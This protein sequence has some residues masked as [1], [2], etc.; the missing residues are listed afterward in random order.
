[1]IGCWAGSPRR[2]AQAVMRYELYGHAPGGKWFKL[3][4]LEELIEFEEFQDAMPGF[5]YRLLKRLKSGQT[6]QMWYR[7][8]PGPGK[9]KV[10]VSFEQML[11]DL[12]PVMEFSKKLEGMLP[13]IRD[14]V[15]WGFP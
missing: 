7:Y 12:K 11:T 5:T 9:E 14:A 3:M 13:K 4:D 6:V 2:R 15:A 8:L 1:M 10:V